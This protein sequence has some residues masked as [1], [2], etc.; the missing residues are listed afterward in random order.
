MKTLFLIPPSNKIP[1]RIYG[2]SFQLYSQPELPILY[3]AASLLAENFNVD[4]CDF[5]LEGNSE[6]KFESFLNS[7]DFDIYIFHTV[8]LSKEIDLKAAKKIR[9]I[10]KNAFM[11]FFGPEPTRVPEDFLFDKKCFV[12]RGEAEITLK[13]LVEILKNNDDFSGLKGISYLRDGNVVNNETFGIIDDLNVLPFPARFLAKKYERNFYN[14]KIPQRPHHLILTSRGCIFRCYFCVPNAVSWAR[15]LEWR[16]YHQ[17]QK[18]PLRIR[19][20]ENIIKEFQSLA[21]QGYKSIWVMD[22]MFLWGEERSLKILDG[23]KGLGLEIGILARADF[24]DKEISKA[25]KEANCKVVDLGVESFDQQVLDYIQK[26]LKAEC[27][28]KAVDCLKQEKIIPEINL[29]FGTSP[30]ETK[31]KIKET[32]KKAIDSN[33]KY[34]LFSIATPFPGTELEKKAKEQKW[35]VEEKFNDLVKNLD[36]SSKSLLSFPELSDKDLEDLIKY[37]KRK[38]YFRPKYIWWR[39]WQIKSFS[40]LIMLVKTAFKILK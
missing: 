18:P 17:N 25:L 37:A 33:V 3:V 40:E 26:D 11:V 20:A 4:F 32:I 30:L 13:K 28:D 31:E 36:P 39:F 35:L 7:S 6:E 29:M 34:V 22:D 38:F 12:V 1:E 14:T 5:T 8:L 2:C 24:I 27:I 15:E 21:K 19:S 10:K 16:K 23:I 9:T